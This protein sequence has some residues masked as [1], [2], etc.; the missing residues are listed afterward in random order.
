LN[1]TT[2]FLI[3]FFPFVRNLHKLE[4]LALTILITKKSRSKVG[5][6]NT[7]DS[8][9]QH[10][11]AHKSQL[12]L[13]TQHTEFTTQME[14]K[15][16]TQRIECVKLEYWSLRMLS[17]CLGD[18]SMRL[19]VPFIAPR[20]LGVVGDK[21]G[22]LSLPSVEW[23]TGQ[24]GAPLDRSFRRSGARSPSKFGISDRCSSGLIDAPDTVRCT[25]NS[26]VHQL[27]VGAVHVWRE[28]CA[29][30]RWRRRPLAH[31]IVWCTTRQSGEL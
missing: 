29:A 12:E 14:L 30:D 13:E 5:W 17:E 16:L 31:R 26:P 9:S 10:N 18:S 7:Q 23:R 11:H 20:Q 15:S 21:L 28:D 8:N 24:S 22:R 1:T 19:G 3:V 4:P 25:P 6:S 27:T 2:F